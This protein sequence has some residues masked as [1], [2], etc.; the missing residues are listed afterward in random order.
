MSASTNP[1][2][3]CVCHVGRRPPNEKRRL[4]AGRD[5]NGRRARRVRPVAPQGTALP[6]PAAPPLTPTPS[7]SMSARLVG[8]GPYRATRLVSGRPPGS[9][10]GSGGSLSPPRGVWGSPGRRFK[11][12]KW[13]NGGGGV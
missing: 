5:S 2:R 7:L 13:E 10:A 12:L 3:R 4:P 1:R 11:A 8:P 6:G 9:A